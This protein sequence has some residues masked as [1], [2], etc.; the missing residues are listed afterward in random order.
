MLYTFPKGFPLP[1]LEPVMN[2]TWP[3][4]SNNKTIGSW[5]YFNKKVGVVDAG[6]YPFYFNDFE[7]L[8]S[9]KY[10]FYLYKN[11][12]VFFADRTTTYGQS[13]RCEADS[14]SK[15]AFTKNG[16]DITGELKITNAG[17]E[18]NQSALEVKEF[19]TSVIRFSA[20]SNI[21]APLVLMQNYY[22]HWEVSVDGQ[23]SIIVPCNYSFMSV[24]VPAGNHEIIFRYN[25]KP[26]KIMALISVSV[27]GLMLVF[28]GLKVFRSSFPS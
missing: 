16:Y 26:V 28:T 19:S 18:K 13:I 6:T 10:K 4:S 22:Q 23:K 17:F 2:Q 12:F 20:H 25:P 7:K 3:D 5:S 27:L 11:P 14:C 21:D 15:T 1:P 9:S 24:W 8:N